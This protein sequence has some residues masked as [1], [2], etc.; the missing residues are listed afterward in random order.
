MEDV[1]LDAIGPGSERVHG[2]M[3]NTEVFRVM[4]DALG[5]GRSAP[6]STATTTAGTA[7]ARK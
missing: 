3:D 2:F 5:L 1:V 6:S 7:R 4:V